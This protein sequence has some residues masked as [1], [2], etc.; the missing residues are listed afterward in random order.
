MVKVITYV[1]GFNLYFGLR[2][3]G[4]K[5]YYWLNIRTLAQKL[6][7]LNQ[8]LIMTKYFTSRII[9]APEKEKRQSTYIEALQTL[10]DFNDFELYY[11]HYRRDPFRCPRCR[12]TSEIPNEK[13]T[14]VNIATEMLLDAVNNRFDIALLI[15]ADSDLVPPIKAIKTHYPE[16]R[17]TVAFPPRRYSA[18]L[19]HAASSSFHISRAKIAQSRFPERVMKTD[20]FV[21]ER[22]SE[23]S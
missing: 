3:S 15:S 14:D 21:L 7:M 23:W 9:D 11:G 19:E 16:K 20:G 2:D 22:P 18:D 12:N 13:M 5:R 17:V 8:E 10:C 1:D 6:L 4:Y